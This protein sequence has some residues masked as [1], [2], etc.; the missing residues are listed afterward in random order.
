MRFFLKGWKRPSFRVSTLKKLP[1]LSILIGC[2]TKLFKIFL[3]LVT[4]SKTCFNHLRFPSNYQLKIIAHSTT[5]LRCFHRTITAHNFI[6]L[7]FLLYKIFSLH[8][9][10]YCFTNFLLGYI[11][12][13][14]VRLQNC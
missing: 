8:L 4:A 3:F 10:F 14:E 11:Q 9:L 1:T 5:V 2:L 13:L 7:V 12:R 6:R